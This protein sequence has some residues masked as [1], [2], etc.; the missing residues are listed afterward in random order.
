MISPP[1]RLQEF[2]DQRAQD[3]QQLLCFILRHDQGRQQANHGVGSHIDQQAMVKRGLGQFSARPVEFDAY[4]HSLATNL[5][6]AVHTLQGRGKSLVDE[7]PQWG[8]LGPSSLKGSPVILHLYV[9][10]V[11]NFVEQAVS[12]GAKVTMPPQ[13]MFWGDRYGQIQDPFGHHWSVA[14]HI[15]DVRPEEIDHEA[16]KGCG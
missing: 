12:A 14:T 2:L 7:F 13:D 8:S 16:L 10:D 3:I 5:L 6:D 1:S 11:D 4:H 9:K 15:R